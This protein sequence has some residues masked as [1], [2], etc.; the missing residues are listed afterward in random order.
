[1]QQERKLDFP[2]LSGSFEEKVELTLP[3]DFRISNLPVRRASS[4][5]WPATPPVTRSRTTSSS[6]RAGWNTKYPRVV[7]TN[8]DSIELRKFAASVGQDLRAQMLYQ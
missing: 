8:A 3:P 7:C 6:S 5:H 4:R 2:C 1:M